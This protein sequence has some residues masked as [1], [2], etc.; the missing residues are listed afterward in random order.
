MATNST[1]IVRQGSLF[2]VDSPLYGKVRG[3]RSVMDYPFFALSKV[4][5]HTPLS[6]EIDDAKIE[7]RPSASGIATMYDKEIIL[8]VASLM[9]Q[10][11]RK[12]GVVGQDFTFKAHDFFRATGKPRPGK[13]E[14]QRF[15]DALE[16]LQGTQIKTNIRTGSQQEKGWFSWLAEATAQFRTAKDGQERMEA[17]RVRLCAWLHRAIMRDGHIYEYDDNYFKLA[18][19]EKRLY[20]I[21]HS[22]CDGEQVE[23]PIEVFAAKVG[24]VGTI[25]QFKRSLKEIDKSGR[26][27]QYRVTLAE[28]LPH[29]PRFD[30]RGRR[31]NTPSTIAV[32]TPRSLP[33]A[34]MIEA[35][36]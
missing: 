19:V 24:S 15:T 30:S 25:A 2:E 12:G 27:P 17:V 6:F 8:Y 32:L 9:A 23:M 29:E 26:I 10:E 34:K 20:E 13:S 28:V 33:A 11:K 18:P 5:V 22:H 14:Y 21:S 36:N 16:R 31:I 4:A 7:I 3:E 1:A 35:A